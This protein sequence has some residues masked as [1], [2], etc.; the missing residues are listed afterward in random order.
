MAEKT[1]R[2]TRGKRHTVSIVS[3]RWLRSI[4]PSIEYY[5]D[6]IR[7]I[8]YAKEKHAR[9]RFR[10]R[11]YD[12][13][14]YDVIVDGTLPCSSQVGMRRIAKQLTDILDYL[15]KYLPYVLDGKYYHLKRFERIR[16]KIYKRIYRK[17]FLKAIRNKVGG[18]RKSWL[19][20]G[21]FVQEYDID[22]KPKPK[23]ILIPMVAVE[24]YVPHTLRVTTS[25][26]SKSTPYLFEFQYQEGDIDDVP[27]LL[28]WDIRLISLVVRATM[29]ISQMDISRPYC[30]QYFLNN[31][32]SSISN[33]DVLAAV[34]ELFNT[35][36]NNPPEISN[37]SFIDMVESKLNIALS[38]YA[39]IDPV[40]QTS[41]IVKDYIE[42]AQIMYVLQ[43]AVDG[44]A[45]FSH[46]GD[47]KSDIQRLLDKI[48]FDE[49][50]QQ[51]SVPPPL[52]SKSFNHLR[53]Y[54]LLADLERTL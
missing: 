51:L 38:Q 20:E 29:V 48:P 32:R 25:I 54:R 53:I 24:N 17:K 28:G 46:S 27:V 33:T 13:S 22:P 10:M 12:T 39:E 19:N 5:Y 16:V 42:I 14:K 21:K 36:L 47:L 41:L 31:C 11:S 34:R 35:L 44:R 40:K 43:N 37:D 30:I 23:P 6:D 18:R 49:M 15:K 4:Q 50:N 9:I 3:W 45:K 1:K 8:W 52:R 7:I 26:L 2:T